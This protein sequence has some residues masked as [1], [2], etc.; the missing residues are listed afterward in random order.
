MTN[1]TPIGLEVSF[2][3]PSDSVVKKKCHAPLLYGRH[4]IV[5]T[6][7]NTLIH[8]RHSLSFVDN[9]TSVNHTQIHHNIIN[10]HSK[11]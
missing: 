8:W 7:K 9:K 6:L 5:H 4:Y 3:N 11:L 1:S 10:N 2:I